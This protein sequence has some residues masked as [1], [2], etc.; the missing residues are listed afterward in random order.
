MSNSVMHDMDVSLNHVIV[1]Q[2]A[3]PPAHSSPMGI[4]RSVFLYFQLLSGTLCEQAA[5]FSI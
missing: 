1:M 3:G 4:L 2:H 5:C